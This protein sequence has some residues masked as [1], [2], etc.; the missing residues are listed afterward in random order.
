MAAPYSMTYTFNRRDVKLNPSKANKYLPDGI[1]EYDEVPTTLKCDVYS[2]GNV[3]VF[4]SMALVYLKESAVVKTIVNEYASDEKISHQTVKEN[5]LEGWLSV[6]VE[7]L[8]PSSSSVPVSTRAIFKTEGLNPS[9]LKISRN[10]ILNA[11]K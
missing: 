5:T 1:Y 7:S 2:F 10:E 8:T 4:G 11:E 9:I 6:P 3:D